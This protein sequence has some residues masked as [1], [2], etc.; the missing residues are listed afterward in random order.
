MQQNTWLIRLLFSIG[1]V[2]LAGY[3]LVP[4]FIYFSLSPAELAEVQKDT[5]A[6]KKHLPKWA[7][8][9]HIVPGLDLQGGVH[10]VLGVDLDKAIADKARRIASRLRD[11]LT[12][13][14]IEFVTVDHLADVGKGDRVQVQ[15]KDEAAMKTFEDD[16]S[17]RYAD[18]AEISRSGTTILFRVHPD[19][20]NKIRTDA[21]DQT[22]KT[23]TNRIDK[24]HVTEPSITKRGSD[25]VQVQLP[26]YTNPEEAKSL[27][28]RTAQLEF[29]MADDESDFL[30][31]LTDLPPWAKLV[32]T[33]FQSKAGE[34]VKDV[35]LEFP[36]EN[37]NDMKHYLAGKVPSGD[38]VK[39]HHLDARAGEGAR[40]RTYTLKADVDLTGDD[41][42]NA[43]VSMGTAENPQPSVSIE[44]SPTGK[45]IFADLTT[46]NVNHRMAI[47]LEDIVDSAPVINEPITGGTAQITMGGS[48]TH[49]EQLHDANQLALVLKAGALPAPVT[50]REERSVGATL[51]KD[52]LEQAK[53]ACLIGAILV[54]CFMLLVYRLG[55]L[56]A[57][58]AAFMNIFLVLATL[59]YFNGSLSLPGIAGLL[60]TVGMAV[61][62]NVIINERIR[63][64]FLAGKTARASVEA[65]YASAFS[66]ILDS[67]VASFLTGWVLYGVGSGPVQ[68]FAV[69][70]LIGIVS[71]MF[72]AVFVTRIFF[73][74]YTLKDRERLLI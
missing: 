32:N 11:D 24:M 43:Q 63:E 68:N 39:F 4:T 25:Q 2:A 34:Y 23:I 38:N 7:P 30:T 36:E 59:S 69:T 70:L 53:K 22:I 5:A 12:E 13:K 48:R 60:L 14:H 74:I 65:G 17:A 33:G 61:D 26:G 10:M 29:Q 71:T 16:L 64:E 52:A 28:G 15:F 57:M 51:G 1:V 9:G 6:F 3:L 45:Q 62:A 49:E 42:V 31:K 58:I 20:V 73:D 67:N 18:L 56:F 40:M 21:V 19:W 50:F 46:K 8:E 72:T 37:Q 47:V 44:F 55:G 66:A 54:T 35:Y 27:I 41:L